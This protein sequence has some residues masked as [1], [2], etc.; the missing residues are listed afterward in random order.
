MEGLE[1][2][3]KEFAFYPQSNREPSNDFRYRNKKLQFV[4]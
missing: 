4:L 2:H 1:G 3:G